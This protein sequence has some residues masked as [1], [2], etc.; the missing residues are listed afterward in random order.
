MPGSRRPM[1][2]TM[3]D[4]IGAPTGPP[5]PGAGP[6]D[7]AWATCLTPFQE[8]RGRDFDYV[9]VG[10]GCVGATVALALLE[11]DPNAR[12]LVLERGGLLLSEHVQN[13]DPAFQPLLTTAV[14]T[15]WS[16]EDGPDRGGFGLAPQVPHLGGRS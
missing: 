8:A 3:L 9:I 13:V 7:G 12:V 5:V 14:A 6:D 11:K 16:Y 1:G 4:L 10:G 2:T 15:P